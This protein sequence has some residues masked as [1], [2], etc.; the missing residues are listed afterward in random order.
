MCQQ[1]FI[2]LF[3]A[4]GGL[5]RARFLSHNIFCQ[6]SIIVYKIC[7]L[8]SKITYWFQHLDDC[9]LHSQSRRMGGR[10]EPKYVVSF[11]KPFKSCFLLIGLCSFS[12]YRSGLYNKFSC[13]DQISRERQSLTVQ[14]P[15]QPIRYVRP[16]DYFHKQTYLTFSEQ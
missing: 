14:K 8:I 11:I 9:F 4:L 5:L 7:H 1:D 6:T 16:V 3:C 15:L 10:F 12:S 13:W 2:L